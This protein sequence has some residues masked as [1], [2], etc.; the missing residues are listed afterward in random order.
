MLPAHLPDVPGGST[1][2]LRASGPPCEEPH[3][4]GNISQIFSTG[5]WNIDL[6]WNRPARWLQFSAKSQGRSRWAVGSLD[7]PLSQSCPPSWLP[8]MCN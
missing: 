6:L 7:P 1:E 2:R 5:G 8:Y 3:D 4:S